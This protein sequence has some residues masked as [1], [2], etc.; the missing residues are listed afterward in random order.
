[1]RSIW[2]LCVLC[3]ITAISGC[4]KVS[5][6]YNA[7][8]PGIWRATLELAVGDQNFNLAEERSEGLLPFNFEV[9]Y[10][11]DT[12]FVIDIMNAEERI[13]LDEIGF[14]RD[15]RSG[16][17]TVR[18]EFPV[19]GS[20]I[21]A[22]YEEDFLEGHFYAPSRGED[23]RIPF[24]A[25]HGKNFR[26]FEINQD[27]KFDASGKWASS[28]EVE[29]DNPY[30]AI[31]HFTQVDNRLTGTFQTETGDYR[32]LEGAVKEDRMYLSVFDGAHAFLFEAKHL[33]DGSMSGIFRSGKH[34]K[35]YWTAERNDTA[36]LTSP[37]ALTYL[38]E[39]YDN[40]EF[41]FPNT[42]GQMVSSADEKFQDKVK[43]IQITG[44][45]CP[46]C[47]DETKF[48]V[49]YLKENSHPDL[50]V[51]ALAFERYSEKEKALKAMR[52]YREK[53]EIP[54][55]LLYAGPSNKTKASEMLP[56]LNRVISYPTLI[57]ID[58]QNRVRK[59][60]TG[61]N[62]PAT[63]E[64]EPFKIDFAETLAALLAE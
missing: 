37:Y 11:D 39:G 10:L 16:K 45:W 56:M 14:G 3:A 44:T 4:I 25:T 22:K 59:I 27:I 17:D 41:N 35:T 5:N 12:R 60:H 30:A 29:T 18:I 21:F 64:F 53:M 46:N 34:Y 57:F 43:L 23:Y 54:F 7:I 24:K 26:F 38:K 15:I 8:P 20:Y 19:Y 55:E 48:L 40:F 62:G 52:T 9:R 33:E 28:F 32:F 2:L 58:K 50:V 49:E 1:M 63:D 42:E 6:K 51:T 36:Q 13:T 61:F 47:R 31:G